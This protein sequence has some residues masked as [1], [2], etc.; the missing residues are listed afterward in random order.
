MG[1]TNKNQI[2]GKHCRYCHAVM[3]QVACVCQ[4]C[5]RH[6]S[7][8]NT[9]FVLQCGA[10]LLTV[11]SVALAW[12]QA[13]SAAGESAKAV[14]ALGAASAAAERAVEATN[15]AEGAARR[16]AG[17]KEDS[18]NAMRL[19]KDVIGTV[20]VVDARLRV[21]EN[22]PPGV[23]DSKSEES[24]PGPIKP[25][26]EAEIQEFSE[27]ALE[28]LKEA[29]YPES[30]TGASGA[31]RQS[32]VR[33]E[34]LHP[35]WAEAVKGLVNNHVLS[36]EAKRCHEMLKRWSAIN[37]QISERMVGGNREDANLARLRRRL[38][39]LGGQLSTARG[40]LE[41]EM[42]RRIATVVGR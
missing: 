30:E 7:F 8:W 39:E 20:A 13:S 25:L 29:L 18:L 42:K 27:Q 35:N 12:G 16:A 15:T 19:V 21:L 6:Q 2:P 23:P 10:L 5:S 31:R 4:I 17:L 28:F 33:M 1:T 36:R 14:D 34:Q 41:S 11:V 26:S 40:G 24:S 37:E 3:P 38:L 22:T 9:H 32:F